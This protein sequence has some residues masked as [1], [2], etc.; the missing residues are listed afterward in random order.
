M[1]ESVLL[2]WLDYL[3]IYFDEDKAFRYQGQKVSL[4][5]QQAFADYKKCQAALE[6]A[7]DENND[8][9][10][11]IQRTYLNDA[12]LIL[13]EAIEYKNNFETFPEKWRQNSDLCWIILVDVICCVFL[14]YLR[15]VKYWKDWDVVIFLASC[16]LLIIFAIMALI[17]PLFTLRDFVHYVILGIDVILLVNIGARNKRQ[18]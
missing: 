13:N 14:L 1:E 18:N 4:K 2:S 16:A 10:V 8:T 11:V 17:V 15:K 3:S 6:Q 7:Q 5:Y 12:Q 9:E